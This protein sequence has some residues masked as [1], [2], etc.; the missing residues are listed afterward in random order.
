MQQSCSSA[1]RPSPVMTGDLCAVR[2]R[3]GGSGPVVKGCKHRQ[4]CLTA[5]RLTGQQHAVA[6]QIRPRHG[7]SR[8]MTASAQVQSPT[9]AILPGLFRRLDL[10]EQG[11]AAAQPP[12]TVDD[13]S[14]RDGVQR[15]CM[16]S[17]SRCW[18]CLRRVRRARRS[19]PRCPSSGPGTTS[20]VRM[21]RQGTSH[22]I[23]MR[24]AAT[25]CC[26]CYLLGRQI[27]LH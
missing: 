4:P 22:T 1:A 20:C 14:S 13:G 17:T 21:A 10:D 19:T 26:S 25:G 3:G 24:R 11:T 16:R 2:T 18:P 9:A 8:S 6:S 5:Q 7:W 27:E 23:C 12:Q 15:R